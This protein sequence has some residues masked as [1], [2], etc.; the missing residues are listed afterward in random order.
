MHLGGAVRWPRNEL[1]CQLEYLS[2]ASWLLHQ[3]EECRE[4]ASSE[5]RP[6]V[7]HLILGI[8]VSLPAHSVGKAVT[9]SARLKGGG[10]RSTLLMEVC[11]WHAQSRAHRMGYVL[12]Y[13]PGKMQS[14]TLHVRQLR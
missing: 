8:T 6:P 14:A 2:V 3:E 4:R 13:R 10:Q 1:G 12:V 11:S 7:Y 5:T 9:I